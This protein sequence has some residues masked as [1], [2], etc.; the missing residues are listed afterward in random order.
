MVQGVRMRMLRLGT[1]KLYYLLEKELKKLKVG[2]DK[3]FKI[4]KVNHLLIEPRKSYHITTDSHHRFKKHK[5]KVATLH[6]LTPCQ[7]HQQSEINMKTYK[8]KNLRENV[9]S[10]I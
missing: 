7:M 6:I 2:R 1:R 10:E 5:N 3:L 4:L 8:S 9:F